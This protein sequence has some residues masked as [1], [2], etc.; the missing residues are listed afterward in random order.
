MSRYCFHILAY[1]FIFVPV[2]A[3]HS[4]H[5][6]KHLTS[7]DGLP[8]TY[9][10][11]VAEDKYGFIWIGTKGGL[12]RY[13]GSRVIPLE[14][15]GVEVDSLPSHYIYTLLM[16]GDSLW[17]GTDAGLS[18]L[19]I[20]TGRISNHYF[21]PD[22]LEKEE[23]ADEKD[24]ETMVWDIY[25]DRQRN[26]W[27]TPSYSGFIKWDR[28]TGAFSSYQICPDPDLPAAYSQND[29]TS[30]RVIIQDVKQDSILW[31]GSISGIIRLNQETGQIR[32]IV[33]DREDEPTNFLVNRKIDLYQSPEGV[34]YTGSWSGGL[35]IYYP[36]TDTYIF[37]R[38]ALSGDF[39]GGHLR[40]IT[41]GEPGHLYLSFGD[42]LYEYKMADHSMRLIR[43]SILKGKYEI[44]FGIEYIDSHHKLYF[45]SNGGVVISDPIVSQF[46]W[47]SLSDFN[48]SRFEVLPRALVEDFY[49]GY[50]T[51]AGQYTDGIYHVNLETEH[52]IKQE[53]P[54]RFQQN[55]AFY[56]WGMDVYQDNT[57]IISADDD[58][59]SLKKGSDKFELLDVQVPVNYAFLMHNL[60]DK[61]GRLWV[62]TRR[63]GLY[64][65]DLANKQLT[66]YGKLQKLPPHVFEPLEDSK[67]NVWMLTNAGHLVFD[68]QKEELLNFDYNKDPDATALVGSAICECPNGE[69]WMAGN[70]EGLIALSRDAPQ[71]GAIE[72][73]PLKDQNGQGVSIYNIACNRNNE[74]WAF[75]AGGVLK[76]DRRTWT[77]QNFNLDYGA[78]KWSD[79]LFQFLKNG[80][81]LIGARD[82]FYT[83]DP[84]KLYVNQTLPRPYVTN[85]T[86]VE[87]PKN[88]MEDHLN[89][90]PIFLKANENVI[91]IEFSAINHTLADRMTYRYML[92]GIDEEWIDPGD[93]RALTYSYLPGGDYV[94][95]LEAANNEGLWSD[96]VYELPIHVGTPWYK[97]TAFWMVFGG[98]ILALAYTYYRVRIRLI[99]KENELR[100]RFE[101]RVAR[102][103]MDALRAQMNP[104]F[105]FNCLNSID[106]YIIRNDKRKASGYLNSFSRLVRLILQNSRS[107]YV[108]LEDELESLRLY[109]QLEQMR[110]KHSFNYEM[111]IEPGLDTHVLEI[112]PMLIQPYVENAIWHGL[113]HREGQEQGKLLIALELSG[114]VIRCTIEDNGV[115]RLAAS[116][117][118]AAQKVKKKSMGMDIT[119]ERIEV[120]NKIYS[121]RNEVMIEDLYNEE[122]EAV[123]TRVVLL[124]PI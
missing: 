81:L 73:I 88:S 24:Q 19:N 69:I 90:V 77:C 42:G 106:S 83:V 116:N 123:G 18:I 53:A 33:Y 34:L 7:E 71:R 22:H 4:F 101:Q 15:I 16:S 79:G 102:L 32:R 118:R 62:G 12:V 54:K 63:D 30:L 9:S 29:Q 72:K 45:A 37:P 5:N 122:H 14:Q 38:S 68:H 36:E 113:N 17:I 21:K 55:G 99:E 3:Q 64:T 39:S 93:K 104:H 60:V 120:I 95:K 28:K 66:D 114:S 111:R 40:K 91:T 8:D 11:E 67:G 6:Y 76:I 13:D 70:S 56:A 108:C 84:E 23:D 61:A 51:I 58:L 117:L 92:E 112:P 65:I 115:G 82:G 48:A 105:I 1:C 98:L 44:Y 94:F 59:I 107:S 100:S 119:G 121:T 27:V 46:K 97:T 74:L 87:G 75:N 47:Y 49:P 26:I 96:S 31:G 2:A 124:I 103:E 85:I 80:D 78:V 41:P 35:S 89:Q 50:V 57:L 109:L 86:S 52:V 25:E 20:T 43:K 110:F 10:F